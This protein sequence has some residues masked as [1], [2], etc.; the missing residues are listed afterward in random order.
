MVK[1]SGTD[2]VEYLVEQAWQDFAQHMQDS[3][4]SESYMEHIKKAAASSDSAAQR[5]PAP[6]AAVD[7]LEDGG[8]G[9]LFWDIV[10]GR[11]DVTPPPVGDLAAKDLE[12]KKASAA[13]AAT[14]LARVRAAQVHPLHPST[15]ETKP[16]TPKPYTP[17]PFASTR[18]HYV[19]CCMANHSLTL[20]TNLPR[21]YAHLSFTH[22]R[23][24]RSRAG[25][26]RGR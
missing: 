9:N 24:R 11:V 14:Q 19:T 3:G 22:D 7:P 16:C 20:T 15:P 4:G 25:A 1:F 13:Q 12:A 10:K 21:P 6:Q 23:H 2:F 8:K 5:A 18:E 17:K 26:R